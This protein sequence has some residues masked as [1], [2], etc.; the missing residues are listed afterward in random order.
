MAL[1][2]VSKLKQRTR[3]SYFAL[4]VCAETFWR[5]LMVSSV[6]GRGVL[7]DRNSESCMEQ[8]VDRAMLV[9]CFLVCFSHNSETGPIGVY[10]FNLFQPFKRHI[11][12]ATCTTMNALRL[13]SQRAVVAR[14]FST[15]APAMPKPPVPV[16]DA[17]RCGVLAVIVL[18]LGSGPRAPALLLDLPAQFFRKRPSTALQ[19][20]FTTQG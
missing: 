4:S 2:V 19:T 10:Y 20:S 8:N 7:K 15:A 1:K 5:R 18:L 9:D 3:V 16:S 11:N 13:S 14:R 6:H 17:L 12:L